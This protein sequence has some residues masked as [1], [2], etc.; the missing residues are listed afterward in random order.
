LFWS[1]SAGS[2]MEVSA[3]MFSGDLP[4]AKVLE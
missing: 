4:L 2:A 3:E 1:L